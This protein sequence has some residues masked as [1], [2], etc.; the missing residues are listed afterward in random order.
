MSEYVNTVDSRG[1]AAIC[2]A[3]LNKTLDQ[4]TDTHCEKVGGYAFYKFLELHTAIFANA[5]N[6]EQYAFAY[7]SKLKTIKFPLSKDVGYFSFYKCTKLEKAD[8]P[9]VTSVN[10]SAFDGC[11]A[12]KTL[13]LRGGTLATLSAVNALEDTPIE[14]GEGYI[15]VPSA[16]YDSYRADSKWSTYANQFRKLEDYTVDGT[17]TGELDVDNRCM[18]RFF[19]VPGT[20]VGY[21]VVTKGSDAVYDGGE[22]TN[23]GDPSATFTG[24]VPEP[25][26]VT[27]D[28]D[29]YAMWKIAPKSVALLERT[30]AGYYRNDTSTTLGR[31]AL[32]KLTGLTSAVFTEVVSVA[33]RCFENDKALS[34]LDF[35]K[36]VDFAS[37]AL[38]DCG[39]DTLILRNSAASTLADKNALSSTKIQSGTGYIYVPSALIDTYKTASGWSTFSA[40][41]RAIEDYPDICGG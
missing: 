15:Y 22:F 27:A 29:C 7:C 13:V 31:C 6:I 32:S 36:K 33:Y 10:R 4:I 5:K 11:S 26:N 9:C 23:P 38:Y 25:V 19:S 41:F 12:L 3:I 16:L 1:D 35:H 14:S 21:K 2:L 40:R 17:V 34:R 37:Q 20:L 18:V 39:L 28:M 24:F 30:L 8:F